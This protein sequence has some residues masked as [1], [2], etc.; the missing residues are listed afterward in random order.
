M[1]ISD[2]F[3]VI[4]LRRNGSKKGI[5][6]LVDIFMGVLFSFPPAVRL[7]RDEAG[8]IER[9]FSNNVRTRCFKIVSVNYEYNVSVRKKSSIPWEMF[10][11]FHSAR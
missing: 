10:I 11:I 4:F 2:G 5:H 6:F 1:N 3:G 8:F 9:F 7:G